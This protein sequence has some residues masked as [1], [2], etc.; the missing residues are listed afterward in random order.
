MLCELDSINNRVCEGPMK[1]VAAVMDALFIVD[2]PFKEHFQRSWRRSGT[3]YSTPS[4]ALLDL[5]DR[6]TRPR[7]MLCSTSMIALLDPE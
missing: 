2:E 1:A 4:N 3:R 6:I 7:V 5:Y